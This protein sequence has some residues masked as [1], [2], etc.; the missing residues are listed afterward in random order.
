MHVV[1]MFIPIA[2]TCVTYVAIFQSARNVSKNATNAERIYALLAQY[3]NTM[4]IIVRN[5]MK[6]AN[7]E[8]KTI[9]FLKE[10]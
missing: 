4:I 9:F 6:E 2:K 3:I 7:F 1:P 5:A 8:T 10:K